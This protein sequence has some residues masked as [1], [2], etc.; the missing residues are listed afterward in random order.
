MKMEQ[1]TPC[2]SF[3]DTATP[4]RPPHGTVEVQPTTH[5]EPRSLGA[6][7]WLL[8]VDAELRSHS[9]HGTCQGAG[10]APARLS[11]GMLGQEQFHFVQNTQH[12]LTSSQFCVLIRNRTACRSVL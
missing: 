2:P 8:H 4:P 5:A 3:H 7:A 11:V 1:V 12:P 9:E 6:P 10:A